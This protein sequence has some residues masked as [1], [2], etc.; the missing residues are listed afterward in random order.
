MRPG[1]ELPGPDGPEE[2][3]R[4]H[5]LTPVALGGRVLGLLVVLT[6]LGLVDRTGSG[7]TALA[8][9]SAIFGGLALL[10][11]LRG[12]VV[13]LVTSYHLRGGELRIDSGLLQK[14]SKRV[15][16]NRVQSVDVLE[17]L[18]ARVFGLA[19]VKVTTAGSQRAAVRLRYLAAP[20]AHRLRADLLARSAGTGERAPEVQA[21][22][23]PL[24]HV[25]H[26]QLVAS[27]LLLLLSW[28]L[29]LLAVGPA[30]AV[31]GHRNSHGGT[32]I[33]GVGLFI[34]FGLA[35]VLTLWRQVNTFWDFTVGDSVDGLRVRHGL[36]STSRQTV[37]PGRVQAVL[38]HQPLSWRPFGW[39][40]V[41]MNVAGYGRSDSS[42]RQTMLI[43]V[44][45][46]AYAEAFVGWLLGGVDL[47]HVPLSPPPRRAA[48]RA[49]GWW[50]FELAGADD[51]LFV[52]RH[53]MLS[54]TVDVVPHERTQSLRLTA[55]PWQRA[56][57]LATVHLDS[58]RGP[59]K[60]RAAH[61][62][63]AEARRMLDR[64]VDRARAARQAGQARQVR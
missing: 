30:L 24:L 50:R 23:R 58:T 20:V 63:A 38:I 53:G 52:A 27:R 11:V 39:A 4:L 59:V 43:P 22:E 18:S 25:P 62:D 34:S 15:R 41:R 48:F 33:V 47:A 56:L 36:L 64:Q 28:R 29:L 17:P 10:V 49:P 5:P 44:A 12:V 1:S 42:D 40:Q 45:D 2:V 55:G 51:R 26:G 31:V 9:R 14:Q 37:P 3:L 8:W 6:L 46:R 60:T 7:S 35:L 19:E 61:R 57:G 13:V 32:A 16:L 21:P 54:R